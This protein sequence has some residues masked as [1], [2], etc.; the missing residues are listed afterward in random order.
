[1]MRMKTILATL[2][3]ALILVGPASVIPAVA[4]TGGGSNVCTTWLKSLFSSESRARKKMVKEGRLELQSLANRR[5]YSPNARP[6]MAFAKADTPQDNFFFGFSYWWFPGNI[7]HPT[8][9]RDFGALGTTFYQAQQTTGVT[10]PAT[11]AVS[12]SEMIDFRL[13][14]PSSVDDAVSPGFGVTS[15]S[16]GGENSGSGSSDNG[17]R[18]GGLDLDSGPGL[19]IGSDFDTPDIG[20]F[21]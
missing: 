4:A 10:L 14:I 20:G 17:G 1:M 19:D 12:Y 21:D 7:W 11:N 3:M 5:T 16:I 13:S 6:P 2:L 9:M 18:D 15:T 8:M